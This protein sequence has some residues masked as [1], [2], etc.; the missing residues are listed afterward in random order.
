MSYTIASLPERLRV[1]IKLV[2]SC[3]IWTGHVL[4]CGTRQGYGR[5]GIGSLNIAGPA[6]WYVHRLVYMLL[7]GEL[8]PGLVLDHLIESGICTDTRCC[9]PAHLEEVTR[10]ENIIR[11]P[12]TMAGAYA[13]RTHCRYGH[14]FTGPN[15]VRLADR[16]VCRTCRIV[17]DH[18]RYPRLGRPHG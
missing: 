5:I 16:R 4:Q 6:T 11:S 7:R 10:G 3:W 18:R 17:S 8:T 15:L 9:N 12:S 1:R 2:G 13:K 14:P